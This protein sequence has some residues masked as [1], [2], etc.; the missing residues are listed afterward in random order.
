MGVSTVLVQIRDECYRV[1][2]PRVVPK[3]YIRYGMFSTREVSFNHAT[4]EKEAGLSVYPAILNP[5][6]T[7]SLSNEM[8]T[9]PSLIGQ[10][11]LCFAVTGREVSTGNDGEPVLRG[12]KLLPYPIHLSCKRA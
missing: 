12:V 11:R 2:W 5:D 4:G 9:C 6:L 3:V 10:G 8:E 7:I 1:S